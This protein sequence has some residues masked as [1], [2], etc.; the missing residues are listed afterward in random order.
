MKTF[1]IFACLMMLSGCAE[2]IVAPEEK[3]VPTV[4]SQEKGGYTTTSSEPGTSC[5][6]QKVFRVVV[7]N[8]QPT[9]LEVPVMCD[10]STYI[11]KGRPQDNNLNIGI[12]NEHR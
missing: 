10:P 8:D 2:Q 4:D 12:Q 6:S 9:L 7:I 5:D 1:F 3:T 11:E